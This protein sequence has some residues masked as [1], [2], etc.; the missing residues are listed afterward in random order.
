MLW[1]PEVSIRA[2]AVTIRVRTIGTSGNPMKTADSTPKRPM[3]RVHRRSGLPA[4]IA[5]SSRIAGVVVSATSSAFVDRCLII[6][7]CMPLTRG[8][9]ERRRG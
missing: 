3:P 2:E 7:A 4:A 6:A 8:P 5:V 9:S 1:R